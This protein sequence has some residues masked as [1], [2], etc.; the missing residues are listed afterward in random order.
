MGDPTK[1]G[2]TDEGEA[3]CN[4][5]LVGG[6]GQTESTKCG[7]ALRKQQGRSLLPAGGKAEEMGTD[8]SE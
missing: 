4:D 8:D 3:P 1:T 2:D 7:A 5:L 6:R